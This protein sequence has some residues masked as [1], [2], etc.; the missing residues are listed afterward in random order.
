MLLSVERRFCF[1]LRP[2]YLSSLQ[3]KLFIMGGVFLFHV[4]HVQYELLDYLVLLLQWNTNSNCIIPFTDFYVPIIN[5]LI[6][7]RG[8]YASWVTKK[9]CTVPPK[10][11]VALAHE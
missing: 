9:V 3:P 8:D 6:D 10:R 1:I 5:E 11:N 4:V 2:L 7:L